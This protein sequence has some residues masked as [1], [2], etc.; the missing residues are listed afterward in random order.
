M[1]IIPAAPLR[2]EQMG[3]PLQE[4]WDNNSLCENLYYSMNLSQSRH[5]TTELKWTIWI[6]SIDFGNG[7]KPIK[8]PHICADKN[9]INKFTHI[10]AHN[11]CINDAKMVILSWKSPKLKN[12]MFELED[13]FYLQWNLITCLKKLLKLYFTIATEKQ[14]QTL[15]RKTR[16]L[17]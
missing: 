3:G 9:A 11:S 14:V 6:C 12:A 17:S 13:Y 4:T 7:E 2:I 16:A 1:A 5:D 15:W 8:F 10:L